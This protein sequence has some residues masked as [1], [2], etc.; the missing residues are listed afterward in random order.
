MLAKMTSMCLF[1]GEKELGIMNSLLV[2]NH[3]FYM[4]PYRVA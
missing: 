1:L 3:D 4:E 2:L